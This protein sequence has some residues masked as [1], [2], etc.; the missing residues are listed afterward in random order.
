[1]LLCLTVWQAP[2][3]TSRAENGLH[4][5]FTSLFVLFCFLFWCFWIMLCMLSNCFMLELPQKERFWTF[6][7]LNDDLEHLL[8]LFQVAGL[9]I[10][11]TAS[12]CFWGKELWHAR[13]NIGDAKTVHVCIIVQAFVSICLLSFS[14]HPKDFGKLKGTENLESFFVT[15]LQL[16]K[17]EMSM[18][19]KGSVLPLLIP[20][21]LVLKYI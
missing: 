15:F 6:V 5:S 9:L 18:Y 2:F 20:G 13:K 19:V 12:R 11:S 10:W 17:I 4:Y 7:G 3:L 1:M 21:R 14:D 8:G 16:W